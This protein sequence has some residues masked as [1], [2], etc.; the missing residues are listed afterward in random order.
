M[1]EILNGMHETI[2]Y[3]CSLGLRLH[4]NVVFEDY[5]EHWHVGIEMIMPIKEGYEVVVGEEHYVLETEDIILIHSGVIHALK[6]PPTGER[7]ILQFETTL[8]YNLKEMETLLFMMPPVILV[9]KKAK[10]PLHAFMKEKLEK[11][12][13]EY[14]GNST[15]REASIY[16]ALIEIYVEL[17]RNEVCRNVAGRQIHSMKQQEYLEAVMSACSFINQ[18]YMENLTLEEVAQIGGFSK[19]HFTR[20]FKQYMNMTFYEYLNSKRVKKAEE[21]LYNAKELSITDVAMGSGFSS[22]SAFNRTFKMLKNCS[23]SD[24]RKIRQQKYESGSL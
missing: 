11:I 15:F 12:I 13:E 14:Q 1:I 7:Y 22:M 8:L 4:H 5:P 2:H 23:P 24:Y 21:L 9:K 18:H 6:A 16:A 3:E 20:I 17:G 10:S 19:Y